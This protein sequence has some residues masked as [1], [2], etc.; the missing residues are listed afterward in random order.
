MSDLD[1][2][3]EPPPMEADW[4]P[5]PPDDEYFSANLPLPDDPFPDDLFHGDYDYIPT[6]DPWLPDDHPPW[7]DLPPASQDGL[8]G[9]ETPEPQA[10]SWH[11]H[12]ARLIG[13]ERETDDGVRYEIGAIELYTHA[14]TGE[15]GGS[16]LPLADFAE[17]DTATE[18]YHD[19]Q[20]QL[21]DAGV[22]PDQ[23]PAFAEHQ[24]QAGAA[25]RGASPDDYA[26]YEYVRDLA[27]GELDGRDSPPDPIVETLVPTAVELGGVALEPPASPPVDDLA[28]F[29]ALGAIGLEAA[30]FNPTHDP[31][32]FYDAETGTAYWIGV[33]QPDADNRDQCV[34]SIL[35]LGRNPDTGELEAQLAPCVPGDWDKAYNAAEYLIQ[36]AQKGGIDH[37]FDAAEGM[38]LATDQRTLWDDPRGIA[39]EPEAAHDIA[40]YTESVWEVAL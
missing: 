2:P 21:H 17:R 28:A 24:A 25:W 16:Y 22:A 37:C 30:D 38:A 31:P 4:L 23:V 40:A 33:F 20:G 8:Q 7:V 12:D 10:E 26:A 27:F 36:V 1:R 15:L 6:D 9:F 18:F 19:L 11:W 14:D 13:V 32:P 3:G 34:T 5:P 35:S 39:L 29:Q